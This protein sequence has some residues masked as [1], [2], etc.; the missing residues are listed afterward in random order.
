MAH[1]AKTRLMP[2]G[3]MRRDSSGAEGA[4]RRG[5]SDLQGGRARRVSLWRTVLGCAVLAYG[6]G[7]QTKGITVLPYVGTVGFTQSAGQY[8]LGASFFTNRVA[9]PVADA[10][11]SGTCAAGG[12]CCYYPPSLPID[13]GATVTALN[14]GAIVAKDGSSPLA[15]LIPG[16]AGVAYATANSGAWQPGDTLSATATGGDVGPFS[17]SV[18]AP[19]AIAGLS[20]SLSGTVD[21]SISADWN[22]S[23]IPATQGGSQLV[24]TLSASSAGPEPGGVLECGIADSAGAMSVPAAI[25]GLLG[26]GSNASVSI[27]RRN[28]ATVATNNARVDIVCDAVTTGNANLQP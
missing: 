7:G 16:D 26:T 21:V 3:P 6:C 22:V 27:T 4:G 15:T 11:T 23:W 13:G 19:A 9:S 25:L 14:A 5:M 28:I 12:T 20:P 8:D 10:G 18:V 2:E 17:G 1:P 24:L